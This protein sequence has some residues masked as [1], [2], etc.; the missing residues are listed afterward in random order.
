[1]RKIIMPLAAL[2]A[3]MLILVG[4]MPWGMPA[5]DLVAGPVDGTD[6]RVLVAENKAMISRIYTLRENEVEDIYQE[7]RLHDNVE[8]RI[9][10]VA[11][12]DNHVYFVRLLGDGT[13]WELV[14]KTGDTLETLY[15]GIFENGQR[16]TGLAVKN[17]IVWITGVASNKASYVYECTAQDG[18]KLKAILPVWWILDVESAEFDGNQIRVTT[19]FDE[20]CFVTLRGDKTYTEEAAERPLP[21]IK[22]EGMGWLLCKKIELL[23]AGALWVVIALSV[24]IATWI[25]MR[26]KRLATR[27]TAVGSEVVFVALL[28]ISVIAFF[29][30]LKYAGLLEACQAVRTVLLIAGY[31]LLVAV[32][33]LRLISGRITKPIGELT[34]QMEQIAEGKV[35]P[36]AVNPGKDELYHMNRAMQEMCMGLSIQD[37]EMNSTIQSYKRFVPGNLT[38]LLER[39]TISEVGLGDNRRVVSNIGLF[40]IGNRAEVRG[41]LEDDAFVDFINYSFGIFY[42]CME[43]NQG[44]MISGALKLS[45]METVFP[46]SAADGVHAGLDFLGRTRKKPEEG[47]PA[48]RPLLLLHRA[49]FLYGLAGKNDRL[50]SYISSAELEFLG[51]YTQKFHETGV[52]IVVTQEY[53][54]QIKNDGFVAR[55]I[56]FVSEN[57]KNS[58]KLYEILDAYP[59]LERKLRAGYDNR[60]QEAIQLFYRND[61]FLARNLFSTLLRACPEDGIVRWYL[62]ACEHFFNQSG[63]AQAD[64][65]LFGIENT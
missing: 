39:A 51:S 61:F 44:C 64:Y 48:P 40:S 16:V 41:L 33:L 49:S 13:Q 45:S 50:F 14:Q 42:D 10:R 36:R 35:A 62:F 5:Q 28:A 30:I 25:C 34:S 60:F 57:E 54:D 17:G 18:V 19:E 4:V 59:E 2:L 65:R 26:A 11:T 31:T 43:E 55:Y 38:E 22:V 12:E 15:Q 7:A 32:L 29:V 8:T 56:G 6:N 3:A 23:A 9:A 58:Y 37:Y 63:E 47:I 27:M 46:D 24:I 53:W 21:E 1:M 52:R 20:H